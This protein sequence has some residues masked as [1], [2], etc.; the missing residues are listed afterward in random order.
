MIRLL[1]AVLVGTLTVCG[2]VAQAEKNDI[3]GASMATKMASAVPSAN[4]RA[5]DLKVFP[6]VPGISAA[7]AGVASEPRKPEPTVAWLLALGFLGLVVLRRTRSGP[8]I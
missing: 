8:M 7:D 5:A 2:P 3:A 6:D 4:A 1:A